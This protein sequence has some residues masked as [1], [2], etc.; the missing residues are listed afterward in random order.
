[1]TGLKLIG[2]CGTNYES[3]RSVGSQLGV[4]AGGIPSLRKIF[5]AGG[6]PTPATVPSP[7]MGGCEIR[8]S[9]Q[10]RTTDLYLG[11]IQDSGADTE[12]SPSIFQQ[13]NRQA[14]ARQRMKLVSRASWLMD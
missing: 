5:P 13:S 8:F 6:G 2:G 11:A 10:A 12:N 1:M 7:A 9:L 14:R 4:L 3:H